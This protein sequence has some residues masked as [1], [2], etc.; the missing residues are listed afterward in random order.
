MTIKTR[1]KS[2]TPLEN[3][4]VKLVFA[5]RSEKVVDLRPNLEGPLFEPIRNDPVK[6]RE[7]RVE[8]DFGGLEW[9]N[10][11]DICPDLLYHGRIPASPE[12]AVR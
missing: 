11:A 10:G 8:Q 1:I 5:D 9:P 4:L 2:V 7:V 6:F 3:L 12:K